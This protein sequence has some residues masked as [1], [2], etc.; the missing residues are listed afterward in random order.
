MP[1]DNLTMAIE[2]TASVACTTDAKR[3]LKRMTDE[4]GKKSYRVVSDAIAVAFD[5]HVLTLDEAGNGN[6]NGNRK[7]TD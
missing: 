3:K 5:A 6:G 2:A 4:T 7:S 1:G